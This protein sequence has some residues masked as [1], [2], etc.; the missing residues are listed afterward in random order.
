MP[1]LDGPSTVALIREIRPD[2]PVIFLT[3]YEMNDMLDDT[4]DDHLTVLIEKP[5]SIV[6][7]SRTVQQSA[8]CH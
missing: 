8:T 7:L 4:H 3:G 5:F 2:I 6:S 1:V